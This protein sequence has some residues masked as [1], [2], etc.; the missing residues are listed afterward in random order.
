MKFVEIRTTQG[1]RLALNPEQ[2]THLFKDPTTGTVVFTLS[3]DRRVMS[4]Q[5]RSL[6]EAVHY[7]NNTNFDTKGIGELK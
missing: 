5:F 2:I 3:T 4:N 1:E 7:C 6:A